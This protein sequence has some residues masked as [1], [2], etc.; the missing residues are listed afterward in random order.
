MTTPPDEGNHEL[1]DMPQLSD[2]QNT[3]A[4]LDRLGSGSATLDDLSDPVLGDLARLA[5]YADAPLTA[6][7]ELERLIE[8]LGDR[9]LYVLDRRDG[10]AADAADEPI[11]LDADGGARRVIDLSDLSGSLDSSDEAARPAAGLDAELGLNGV[12]ARTDDQASGVTSLALM[13]SLRAARR[14]KDPRAAGLQGLA[15]QMALPAASFIAIALLSGGVSAVVAGDPMAPIN[16]VQRITSQLP[17]FGGSAKDKVTAV[18]SDIDR[19]EASLTNLPRAKEYLKS[20]EA[21]MSDVPDD[22]KPELAARIADV[23][24][25]LTAAVPAQTD[26]AA[27]P[28]A[29]PSVP[30]ITAEPS[31]PVSP[32][33]EPTE[34]PVETSAS[35]PTATP[36]DDT[37]PTEPETTADAESAAVDDKP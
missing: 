13:R 17:G 29:T 18:E 7:P 37:P 35:Q 4:L 19:A 15:Q 25:S 28:S 14:P 27:V 33:A 20:A 16:G 2:L 23:K 8:L 31:T 12:A 10:S 9:P 26:P 36:T 32:S 30:S 3:D 24:S 1:A 22:R 6:P 34:P 21:K 5:A 11:R